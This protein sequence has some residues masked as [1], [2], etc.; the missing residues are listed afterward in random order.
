MHP[1]NDRTCE[2]GVSVSRVSTYLNFSGDAEEAF[3]FYAAVFHTEYA[4]PL[5][6]FGDVPGPA[7]LSEEESQKVLNV[8]LPILNGHVI[9]GTDMLASMGNV[10]RIGNNTTI[11]LETDSREQADDLFDA[12]SA[13][14]SE[15]QEMGDMFWGACWGV[16]LDHFG[17]RWMISHT[18]PSH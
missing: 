17:I 15:I 2:I 5:V 11:V 18:P 14:G 4:T 3:E 7:T 12:L 8:V 13:R 6:R 10:A 9:M 16:G 1:Y